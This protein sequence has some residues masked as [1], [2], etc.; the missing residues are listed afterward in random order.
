MDN[1]KLKVRAVKTD[2]Q[3][4]SKLDSITNKMNEIADSMFGNPSQDNTTR[5]EV[6]EKSIE[7]AFSNL[8]NNTKDCHNVVYGVGNDSTNP[9]RMATL[10]DFKVQQISLEEVI[11]QANEAQQ[12]EPAENN[13]DIDFDK[14]INVD[15]SS[16]NDQ[17]SGELLSDIETI[18]AENT[19]LKNANSEL[20][21]EL[22]TAKAENANLKDLALGL[23]QAE[24]VYQDFFNKI[25]ETSPKLNEELEATKQELQKYKDINKD[26]AEKLNSAL[27]QN[28]QLHQQN[29]EM[30]GS[31]SEASKNISDKDHEIETTKKSFVIL[32]KENKSL[33]ESN[34]KA[35]KIAEDL[36]EK[37]VSVLNDREALKAENAEMREVITQIHKY[38]VFPG[39][40]FK[41]I[42]SVKSTADKARYDKSVGA[43]QM[44]SVNNVVNSLFRN[45]FGINPEDNSNKESSE[46][47]GKNPTDRTNYF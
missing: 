44:E 35:T 11:A 36:R 34:S 16:E 45:F 4:P 9:P 42:N 2:D 1:R 24:N 28:A 14:F 43:D 27:Q 31:L 25:S 38:S 13:S 26:I 21:L 46:N 3:K 20:K 30:Y 40:A 12:E 29:I 10:D 37:L 33:R 8:Q 47:P 6:F 7:E 5:N 23:L 22:E 39:N 41:F 19:S 18:L 32:S 17:Y 15:D